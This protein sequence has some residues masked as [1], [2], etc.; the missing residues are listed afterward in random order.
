MQNGFSDEGAH[1]PVTDPSRRYIRKK[2]L[3]KGQFK[4]VFMAFDEEEALEVA[5][6][7]IDFTSKQND[8]GKIRRE[9][10]L[11]QNLHHPNVILFHTSWID[12][13]RG[14]FIFITELMTSGTLKDFIASR[15]SRPLRPHITRRWCRQILSGLHYLHSSNVMHR[16]L[17][18][19]N[20]FI[21]GNK[22]EVKI[23][24]LGLS[25]CG[26]TQA[27]T[28]TGTPEFMAPEIYDENYTNSVDIW[29]FG[30]CV[31]EMVTGEYPYSECQNVGQVYKKVSNG[32]LP[33]ALQKVDDPLCKDMI[34]QCLQVEPSKRPTAKQLLDCPFLRDDDTQ[35]ESCTNVDNKSFTA[36]CVESDGD[37][38]EKNGN[39]CPQTPSARCLTSRKEVDAFLTWAQQSPS[40]LRYTVL[41]LGAMYGMIPHST[42]LEFESQAKHVQQQALHTQPAV[43]PFFTPEKYKCQW[44]AT[45]VGLSPIGPMRSSGQSHPLVPEKTSPSVNDALHTAPSQ[46]EREQKAKE[47]E[48]RILESFMSTVSLHK[49]DQHGAT[50]PHQQVEHPPPASQPSNAHHVH[51]TPH[52]Q[53][54]SASFSYAPHHPSPSTEGP[55][56]AF[57][58]LCPL[59]KEIDV[60]QLSRQSSLNADQIAAQYSQ[61]TAPNNSTHLHQPPQHNPLPTT[62]Q[63]TPGLWNNASRIEDWLFNSHAQGNGTPPQHNPLQHSFTN[64]LGDQQHSHHG[65]GNGTLRQRSSSFAYAPTHKNE[66]IFST[67]T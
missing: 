51:H 23:G 36:L 28:V 11:L 3:G 65:I 4:E 52:H 46:D 54:H 24:D 6:N 34:E 47:S 14:C 61:H 56:D 40:V 30:N 60:P 43:T 57:A 17:K 45:D 13:E 27:R 8:L 26:V 2:R 66:D 63:D 32:I 21:N 58:D 19:D 20:I 55:G 31:L 35:S 44:V 12:E 62:S 25:V 18:C 49:E 67:L 53:H 38:T 64:G 50:R 42:L 1:H 29:S 16:D 41:H 5:W 10:G 37:T 7:E 59:H 15:G 39:S 9:V 33:L 22:G 48:Q